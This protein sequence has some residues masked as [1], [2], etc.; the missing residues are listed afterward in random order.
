ML[1]TFDGISLQDPSGRIGSTVGALELNDR[2]FISSL[3]GSRIAMLDMESI[4]GYT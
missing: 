3:Q 1:T 4:R 2:L